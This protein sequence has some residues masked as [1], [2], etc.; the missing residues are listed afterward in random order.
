MKN[1]LTLCL[2][3]I[4]TQTA[5]SQDCGPYFAFRKGTKM[6]LTSY[7][8]KDKPIVLTKYEM[9]DYKPVADGTSLVFST[10]TYDA[11]GNLLVKGESVGKCSG[12]RYYTDVRNIAS[13][14][15]PKSANIDVDVSG[16]LLAYPA[17]LSAGD[18]LPNASINMKASMGSIT[19]LNTTV[20]ITDRQVVGLETVETPAGRFDCVKITYTLTM[21]NRSMD[22]AEYLAKGIGVVKSEQ[23]DSN[24]RKQS[25]TML[26]RLAK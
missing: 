18:K 14:M 12:G 17:T 10:A 16:D 25:S 8:K 4:L 9:I 15:M 21:R 11:K 5:Y 26:T 19:I 2:L 7:D 20:N 23:V 3:L 24:G 1:P 6:E 22:A 13:D